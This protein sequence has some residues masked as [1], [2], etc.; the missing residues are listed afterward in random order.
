MPATTAVKIKDTT[1]MAERKIKMNTKAIEEICEGKKKKATIAIE[2][3][4]T[5]SAAE[6]KKRMDTEAIKRIIE[7]RRMMDTCHT[8]IL[9][10]DHYLLAFDLLLIAS[11]CLTPI[12]V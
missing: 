10:G 7:R 9:S 11:K 5:T 1:I 4:E 3:E 6:E 12:V 2:I 8:L